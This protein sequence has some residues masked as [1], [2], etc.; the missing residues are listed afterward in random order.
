MPSVGSMSTPTHRGLVRALD[1][2]KA[3]ES[4][5]DA[6]LAAALDVRPCVISNWRAER[7]RIGEESRW[8]VRTLLAK[9]ARRIEGEL[10]C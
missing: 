2:V 3:S 6:Q 9:Y 10:A 7:S 4:W 1:A 8:K 5:T